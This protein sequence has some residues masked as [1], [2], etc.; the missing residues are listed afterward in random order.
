[1]STV[2]LITAAYFLLGM[3]IILSLTRG[4]QPGRAG[5]QWKKYGMY[6][7]IVH[8]MIFAI[9]YGGPL[10]VLLSAMIVLGAAYELLRVWQKDKAR[11]RKVLHASLVLFALMAAGLMT[12]AW[13]GS[14]VEMLFVYVIVFTFDGFSQLSGQLFGKRKL[15]PAI[16]PGKTVEGLAGGFS[17]S[18]LT[19]FICRS[20]T[21]FSVAET[22]VYAA[23]L[24]CSALAGDL[25]ASYYKRLHKVKDY[26]GLIPGHGGL[27]DRFDSFLAAGAAWCPVHF[28]VYG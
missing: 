16:S 15:A 3:I 9:L 14:T 1:M 8:L 24:A 6:L 11:S 28:I 23:L 19:A 5:E 7:L 12:S 21:G 18:L 13:T 27:L 20:W 10:F 17:V 2:F 22:L 4:S 25:L 26:S